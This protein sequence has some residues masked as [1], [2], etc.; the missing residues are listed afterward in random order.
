MRTAVVDLFCGVGGL[1]CGL[2]KAGLKVVVGIDNDPT[3]KY[4]YETNNKVPFLTEDVSELPSSKISE[5]FD[6]AD[7]KILVG[8]APCQRFSKQASKYLDTFDRKTDKRWNLLKSFAGYIRDVEPD[9]VSM[10]NVP[11]L[12]KYDVFQEFEKNLLDLGYKVD[13]HIV[14]CSKYGLPQK[15]RRLVLLASRLSEIKLL[16]AEDA[17]FAEKRSVRSAIGGL[18][19]IKHGQ[20]DSED[21]LHR[22]AGLTAINMERMKQSRP[23]GTWRD[24]NESLLPN[25]YRKE[26]GKTYSGVY[27]RMR[28]DDPSPTI[29]TQFY[30]FGT[31]RYGHPEQH[32]ALSLREGA[33]LQTFPEDYKFFENVE[34]MS[35]STI[36]RHIGNAVP[37]DLGRIIGLSI[38]EHLKESTGKNYK[39]VKYVTK[40]EISYAG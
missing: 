8:C 4:A 17:R 6:D 15:R 14:D 25:C 22:S 11:E 24:W 12:G 5:L 36:S 13:W 35:I 37:V 20:T 27:G 9:I 33:L 38:Q 2:K 3:C 7:I 34:G 29:T 16:P 23:G 1:T 18:G 30:S 28:W 19:K 40:L 39:K 31:G 32:R 21:P 10:E 26:S